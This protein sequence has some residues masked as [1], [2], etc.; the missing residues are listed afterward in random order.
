MAP[1]RPFVCFATCSFT[2]PCSLSM[3]KSISS[4][5]S[6]GSLRRS[7]TSLSRADRTRSSSLPNLVMALP[8][9]TF[10]TPGTS[11]VLSPRASAARAV[12]SRIR[13]SGLSRYACA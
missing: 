12:L 6:W 5:C 8:T 2:S 4:V 10:P 3:I 1:T 11:T 7:D 9:F 13:A